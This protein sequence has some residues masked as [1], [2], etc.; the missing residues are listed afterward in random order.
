V[1]PK[2]Y[3]LYEK[4]LRHKSVVGSGKFCHKD[5]NERLELLGDAVLDTVI[6]EY[7]FYKFPEAD[8]GSLTKIRARIVNRQTLSEVGLR[9]EL[10]QIIEA[11][12][13]EDDSNS[14]IIGNAL[15]AWLG[16]I[17]LDRG[18]DAAK[19][20]RRKPLTQKILRH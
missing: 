20:K 18:F 6:T 1:T 15:E 10:D 11:R 12:I 14:K 17:Y 13:S 7:L 9:A 2:S 19:K 5:C 4:A 8:E 16:A 3:S